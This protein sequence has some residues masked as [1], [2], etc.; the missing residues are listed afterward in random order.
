M[1]LA[2]GKGG[3]AGSRAALWTCFGARLWRV[4]QSRGGPSPSP[5]PY[6]T[7]TPTPTLSPLR[8]QRQERAEERRKSMAGEEG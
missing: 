5:S 8:C 1:E 3:L 4:V 7:S 6:P 2:A